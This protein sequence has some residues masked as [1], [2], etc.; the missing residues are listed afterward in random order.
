MRATMTL[1]NEWQWSGGFA[2]YISWAEGNASIPYPVRALPLQVL[3][4]SILT[5]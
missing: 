2:Q 3:P 1:N 5:K 4:V